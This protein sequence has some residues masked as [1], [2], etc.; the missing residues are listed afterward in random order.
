MKFTLGILLSII[1]FL[2][3]QNSSISAERE[4]NKSKIN[5][6]IFTVWQVKKGDTLWEISKKNKDLYEIIER[7][8]RID[9]FHI[10]VG[11]K[12]LIPTS[13]TA[14]K[15]F[16]PVPPRLEL[17]KKRVVV[18]FLKEQYFGF[19]QLGKLVFWGPISSGT[20]KHPTPTGKFKVLWKTKT[21]Y[22]KKYKASMPYAICL[23]N[24]LGIFIHAQALPGRP[25]SHGCIRLLKSDAKR[26]FGLLCKEDDIIIR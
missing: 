5:P 6:E 9:E 4:S 16:I 22:S 18:V 14:A 25:A 10:R 17:K 7:V 20:Q 12:I 1:I 11:Q 26:L 19:Y 8:N 13:E 2:G 15:N 23:S 3:F 24:T 21:Y